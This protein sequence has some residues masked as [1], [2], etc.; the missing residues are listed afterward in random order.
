[1]SSS[2]S[3]LNDLVVS[4]IANVNI[5]DEKT[6]DIAIKFTNLL[7]NNKIKLLDIIL[8]LKVKL[9]SEDDNERRK[10][11]TCLSTI[12]FNMKVDQLLKNDVSVIF[13]FYLSKI[14]DTTVLKECFMGLDSIISMKY[15]SMDETITILTILQK[16]YKSSNYLAAVR[17]YPFSILETIYNKWPIQLK[18][19]KNFA[20]LFIQTYINIAS[21]EKDPKN[22]LISFKLNRIIT[23]NCN[24]IAKN[25]AQSLFDI[26]FSY[27]PITFKPPK[28]DPYKITNVDLKIALR[29]AISS[30]DIFAVDAFGNLIDKLS[31]TSPAIKNDTLLTILDCIKNFGG[32]ACLPGW[33]Q[34]WNALKFEIMHSGD[35]SE[36]T[37]LDPMVQNNT[38]TNSISNIESNYKLS[39]EV[40]RALALK[41][42]LLD[43]AAFTKYVT[44]I[45][46]EL[47]PNFTYSK[48]LRQSCDILSSIGSANLATFNKVID[49][50]LPLFLENTTEISKLKL[51]L[52]NL[53]FFLDSYI[54][55]SNEIKEDEEATNTFI[56]SN[57]LNNYKDDILMILG[58]ALTGNSKIEVTIR[59]LSV[60]Q[61]T[62]LIRMN[63]YLN[64]EE[65]SLIIQYLTETI[66]TDANKN[67]YCA[68]LE[69]LKTI[70]KTYENLIYEISLKELLNLLPKHFNDLVI[71]HKDDEIIQIE[72]ILKV[73]L[74]FTTSRHT[75][76][77][78]S[79]VALCSKLFEIFNSDADNTA[80]YCFLLLSTAYS[81]F[82]NNF[83]SLGES[84]ATNIKDLIEPSLF[85]I[86][87]ETN[88]NNA[89]LY[90][91]QNISLLS[92][93]LYFSNIKYKRECHQIELEKVNKFFM[94]D[95]HLLDTPS[96][97]I[98]PW[99]KILCAI[100]KE[101]MFEQLDLIIEKDI[102]LIQDKNTNMTSFEKLGYM[103]LLMVLV[104]KWYTSETEKELVEKYINWENYSTINLEMIAW[105]GKG[106]I[107]KNSPSSVIILSHFLS[108]LE[109][110]TVGVVASKLFELFVID[111]SSMAKYKGIIW[112][113]NIKLLYKQKFFNDVFQKL[114][115]SYSESDLSLTIRCNYLT[116]L[117]LVLKHTPSKLVEQFM[118]DLLPMLL[119]ALEMPNSEVRISALD[120]LKD[121]T[122][123]FCLLIS[124]NINTLIPLLLKLVIPGSKYNNVT[125]KLLSLQLLELLAI[126]VPL[127]YLQPYKEEIINGLLLTLS[128]KK[129]V[130]RK[131]CIDTRQV[132]HE[133]GQ[134]PFE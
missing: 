80:D 18:E 102:S 96:R 69:G 26:L 2:N 74:D 77:K 64:N 37:Y 118:N 106:L 55:I 11:L 131:Q 132:Y 125:V 41:L 46:E 16:D 38:S 75:L 84:S 127:N 124:D 108:L 68:C 70:S 1:M 129:R 91:D 113:N 19:N 87:K 94:N 56:K 109:D 83:A 66:L 22:L 4:F 114:V 90:D 60:I 99:V 49:L 98:L 95:V 28:D 76:I 35:G 119:Q 25:F 101:C 121:T 97:L 61:F 47:K 82:Q 42:V 134:V 72:V 120:T 133:L 79:I 6:S 107:M 117:S 53:S 12:L 23:K 8:A 128:D 104:N 103:E 50:T 112:N 116:A 89:V 9:I 14:E 43:E 63:G 92:N 122:E 130:V 36:S 110:E 62:K 3:E 24:E 58:M 21:G 39:L 32:A 115:K 71:Y 123:K 34:M 65:I 85:K 17:N 13:N 29:S 81:L 31:A 48:D 44:H 51:I 100:D 27:F 30:S 59:T 7:E 126:T 52:L 33:L 78:E 20:T 111:I 86:L 88:N 67:I 93:I 5:N 54:K 73:I 105:I 45:L 57:H 40:L 10:A 15:I